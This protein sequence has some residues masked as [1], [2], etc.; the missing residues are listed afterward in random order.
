M[1][2]DQTLDSL[3]QSSRGLREVGRKNLHPGDFVIVKTAN[4]TYSLQV[5]VDGT[6]TVSGGWF[7]LKGTSPV[8]TSIRGCTWGGSAI[9]VDIIAACGLRIEFANRIIT[10]PIQKI[11]VFSRWQKN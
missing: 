8:K 7:D 4:S 3:V 11:F 10:S 5:E 6:F 9:K 2:I 1:I